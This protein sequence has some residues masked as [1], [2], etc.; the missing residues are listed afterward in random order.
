[1][2]VLSASKVMVDIDE[3]GSGVERGRNVTSDGVRARISK[4]LALG[5]LSFINCL[6]ILNKSF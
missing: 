4:D 6:P 5:S 1:M 2:V 3:S